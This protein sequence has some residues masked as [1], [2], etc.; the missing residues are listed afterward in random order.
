EVVRLAI[1]GSVLLL[2]QSRGAWFGLAAGL[3]ALMAWH[4]P[5]S[6]RWLGVLLVTA[7]AVIAVAGGRNLWELASQHTGPGLE[8]QFGGRLELW[9]TALHAIQEFPLTGMG[10][11]AF[12]S[13][14][15]V[16][17]PAYL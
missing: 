13:V 1:T 2:T 4:S 9:S 7:V 10:M 15:P 8:I 6:R 3:S 5:R 14:M 12:R 17:Y 11:N 16:L